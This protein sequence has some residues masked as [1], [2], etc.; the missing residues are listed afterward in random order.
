[1]ELL[2]LITV[3]N[4][5]K[6]TVLIEMEAA[7]TRSVS[8]LFETTS[9]RCCW[10][11]NSLGRD[12]PT[13]LPPGKSLS[14]AVRLLRSQTV[15]YHASNESSTAFCVI[16]TSPSLA[17]PIHLTVQCLFCCYWFLLI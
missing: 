14:T 5:E 9:K 11:T 13:K 2:G 1:M 3:K 4:A 6:C 12:A 16:T 7:L 10:R 17:L 15:A 8:I